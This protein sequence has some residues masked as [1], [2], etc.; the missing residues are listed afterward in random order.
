MGGS[1]GDVVEV[2]VPQVKQRKDCDG[3]EAAEGLENELRR[4]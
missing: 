1:P 3:S 4:R 2:P